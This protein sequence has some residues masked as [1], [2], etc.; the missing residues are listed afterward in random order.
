MVVCLKIP[1]WFWGREGEFDYI[2]WLI[3]QTSCLWENMSQIINSRERSPRN[4]QGQSLATRWDGTSDWFP[5]QRVTVTSVCIISSCI[6]WI[7]EQAGIW[8]WSIIKSYVMLTNTKR[9]E[10]NE[11][12]TYGIQFT[13]EDSFII[14]DPECSLPWHK[15]ELRRNI[16]FSLCIIPLNTSN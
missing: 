15:K 13:D 10:G 4:Q 9:L 12:N 8:Y 7:K 14:K 5:S 11:V 6:Y 1:V 3:L 16:Y 2:W